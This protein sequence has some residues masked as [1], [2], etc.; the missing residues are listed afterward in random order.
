TT[1][2]TSIPAGK[3][4]FCDDTRSYISQCKDVN[5]LGEPANCGAPKL[6]EN[7]HCIENPNGDDYCT[8]KVYNNNTQNNTNDSVTNPLIQEDLNCENNSG[9]EAGCKSS[10]CFY[11]SLTKK[12]TNVSSS[13]ELVHSV[14]STPI[15]VCSQINSIADVKNRIKMC[16]TFSDLCTLSKNSQCVSKEIVAG[17]SCA[18]LVKSACDQ[19]PDCIYSGEPAKCRSKSISEE[20]FANCAVK[21]ESSC[22]SDEKC[23]WERNL[24][25]C[26]NKSSSILTDQQIDCDNEKYESKQGLATPECK[27][28]NTNNQCTTQYKDGVGYECVSI[29]EIANYGYQGGAGICVAINNAVFEINQGPGTGQGYSHNDA[30][31]CA[32]DIVVYNADITAQVQADMK[33]CYTTQASTGCTAIITNNDNTQFELGHLDEKSC[34]DIG[35]NNKGSCDKLITGN[36]GDYSTGAH[37]HYGMVGVSGQECDDGKVEELIESFPGSE[38]FS[39]DK[40]LE[41][42]AIDTS[43]NGA[44]GSLMRYDTDLFSK[45]NHLSNNKVNA[46]EN[47][48]VEN[49]DP[50][51]YTFSQGNEVK[52]ALYVSSDTQVLLFDDSNGNNV[53]DE[54]EVLLS[55]DGL[56]S[57]GYTI[58]QKSSSQMYTINKGWNLVHF[59]YVFEGEESQEIKTASDLMYIM[60]AQGAD[61]T[62]ISTYRD[63]NFIM[64]TT[65][66]LEDGS[67]VEFGE[68]FNII[69][70]EAYFLLSYKNAEVEI[71]GMQIDG[72]LEIPLQTGWNLVG[73][74]NS[75]KENYSAFD[76]LSQMNTNGISSDTISKW[77]SG[78]Y[79]NVV[80]I[81]DTEY[82]YDYKLFPQQGYFVRVLS[83]GTNSFSPK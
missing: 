70:G 65:R 15:L 50:G 81:D 74:F 55:I 2:T 9:N 37:L 35:L 46:Q 3:K 11:N 13:T 78:K 5:D 40:K 62:N 54:G 16:N 31:G 7:G 82:G 71:T 23:K 61:V 67:A 43:T 47:S 41:Y 49:F 27:F 60:N 14:T 4:Y 17:S 29:N 59:P 83:Q 69:P 56:K 64:F 76:I 73:I 12:C 36:T 52:K 18:K 79:V 32:F 80:K 72:S 57:L 26:I 10:G 1:T 33:D 58:E 34:L 38:F 42:A 68:D 6:C 19:R 28:E 63:G 39:C 30:Y 66:L 21:N 75:E 77:E 22:I 51:F 20:E 48:N 25:K 8:T 53:K 45:L 44:G 24:N